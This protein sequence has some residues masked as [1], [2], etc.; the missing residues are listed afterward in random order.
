M[1]VLENIE[2]T[3]F[4][5][6]TKQAGEALM[7][8]TNG[9]GLATTDW[10]RD[11]LPD[12]LTSPSEFSVQLLVN[13]STTKYSALWIQLVGTTNARHRSGGSLRCGF[14]MET[15][16]GGRQLRVSEPLGAHVCDPRFC[17]TGDVARHMAGWSLCRI[18]PR[19]SVRTNCSAGRFWGHL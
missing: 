6:V 11:G 1:V 14:P 4:E 7:V 17:S 18:H 8:L 16:E 15:T 9:R 13:Q 5:E 2:K 12:L 19:K 10:N 3:H